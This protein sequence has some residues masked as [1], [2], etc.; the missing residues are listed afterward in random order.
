M[1]DITKARFFLQSKGSKLKDLQT[2]GLMVATASS[3]Y[4][5]VRMRRSGMSGDHE[6]VD[7][8]EVDAL[9]DYALLKY[10]ER[11]NKLPENARAVISNAVSWEDKREIAVGWM[12][13]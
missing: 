8:A 3:N 13:G 2:F 6:V 5:D 1:N 9:I 10:M 7:P 4:R 11:T 12:R